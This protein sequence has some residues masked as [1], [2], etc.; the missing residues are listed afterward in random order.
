[1]TL[2]CFCSL[3]LGW[4]PLLRVAIQP[5]LLSSTEV[6]AVCAWYFL[7][8]QREV[9]WRYIDTCSGEYLQ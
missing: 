9:L 8:M 2:Y 5:A 3:R 4:Q 1:M 6:V 7:T